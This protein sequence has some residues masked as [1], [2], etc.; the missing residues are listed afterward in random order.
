M[1]VGA[2]V[3]IWELVR[4]LRTVRPGARR[5]RGKGRDP[6][7]LPDVAKHRDEPLLPQYRPGVSSTA[8]SARHA[9]SAGI[10]RAPH[11][12]A[13]GKAPA[14]V[15]SPVPPRRVDCRVVGQHREPP[16]PGAGHTASSAGTRR[17]S[18]LPRASR[19]GHRLAAAAPAH[20]PPS[21][22]GDT[23]PSPRPDP[24]STTSWETSAW[25]L[26][27]RHRRD[28]L[29]VR[30]HRG[31]RRDE[32]C[33]LGRQGALRQLVTLVPVRPCCIAGST[34]EIRRSEAIGYSMHPPSSGS[35]SVSCVLTV[36]PR[37]GRSPS[38]VPRRTGCTVGHQRWQQGRA[39]RGIGPRDGGATALGVVRALPG[40]HQGPLRRPLPPRGRNRLA[41][42]RQRFWTRCHAR[43]HEA[44]RPIFGG[45][46]SPAS[47]ATVS[48]C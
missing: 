28:D 18:R 1:R 22:P 30:G 14:T 36:A 16:R 9:A 39:R 40:G 48:V 27:G 4:A 20:T 46:N 32:P 15:P 11:G 13:K 42:G 41:D 23:S 5:W 7:Q 44:A 38:R 19:G 12:F 8:R 10:A 29:R 31:H 37:A 34:G 26:A 2:L 35:G 21:G 33:L 25:W 17:R 45:P 43:P 6:V 47:A 24:P 3:P